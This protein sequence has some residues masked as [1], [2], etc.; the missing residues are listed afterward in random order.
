MMQ[1]HKYRLHELENQI[2]WEREVYVELL[3]KHLKDKEAE[4]K[5]HEAEMKAA[6]NRR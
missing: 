6:R 2:P 1:N 4:M 3:L 5:K